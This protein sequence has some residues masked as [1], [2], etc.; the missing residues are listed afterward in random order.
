MSKGLGFMSQ[1]SFLEAVAEPNPGW[2]PT[3]AAGQMRLAGFVARAGRDYTKNRNFDLG[4]DDRSNVSCLSPWIRHRLVSEQEVLEAIRQQ[5][6]FS[7]AE[8]FIE[9]VFWRG[10]F[11]GWFEQRPDVWRRY[12]ADVSNLLKQLAAEPDFEKNYRH[13]CEGVTGIDC[14]DT[15]AQELVATGYLHNH[16]RMWFASIWIFTLKLPWQLGADFFYRH[17][18]DGDPAANTLSWRWVAGLHTKGKTYLARPDNIATFTKGKFGK[19]EVLAKVAPALR[20]NVQDALVPFQPDQ[21]PT[22]DGRYGLLITEEDCSPGSLG[23][24]QSPAVALGVLA[25]SAR[26][27]LSIGEPASRF[28]RGA[29]VDALAR[30]ADAHAV[31]IKLIDENWEAAL[32]SYAL[33]HRLEVIV[34]PYTPVGPVADILNCAAQRLAAHDIK[35]LRVARPYDQAVWPHATKGFFAVKQQIPS[36]LSDLG[37]GV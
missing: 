7:S 11:K 30:I 25:T 22:I 29:V 16:A 23:L 19:I 13:A 2:V 17:L 9:E 8:K 5:H 35:V 14:F 36:I 18:L 20:E 12:R 15:F 10:Y 37:I 3:R 28:A 32:E 34:T 26:S 21:N 27:S 1:L 6:R 33:A 4:P 24:A 31:E